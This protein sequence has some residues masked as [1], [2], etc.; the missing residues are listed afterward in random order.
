M[1][2]TQ[3]LKSIMDMDQDQ[4]AEA[5]PRLREEALKAEETLRIA[6]QGVRS[7]N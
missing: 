7:A 6:Q 4:L 2:A 3:T 1:E 5:L